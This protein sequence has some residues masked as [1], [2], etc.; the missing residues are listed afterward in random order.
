MKIKNKKILEKIL[1][2]IP[3]L[4]GFPF[5]GI[6]AVLSR[7]SIFFKNLKDISIQI[8]IILI[9]IIFPI[10]IFFLILYIKDFIN[11]I[12]KPEYI[13]FK[14][15][16]Y[17]DWLLKW[18]YRYLSKTK[19]YII[20]N[21]KSFCKC[22]CAMSANING[23]IRNGNDICPICKNKILAFNGDRHTVEEIKNIIH[24]KIS[25]KQF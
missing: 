6:L 18:D 25:N 16:K 9:I 7:I 13:N 14:S 20:I 8:P 2:F 21:I 10:F 5:I 11:N 22:S 24:Y 4:S 19:K 23:G 15:M 3:I 17:K 1:Y 12:K